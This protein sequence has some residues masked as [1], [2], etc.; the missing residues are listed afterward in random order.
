MDKKEKE[1]QERLARGETAE[2]TPKRRGRKP[3]TAEEKLQSR[4]AKKKSKQQ[5]KRDKREEKKM[6]KQRLK[7]E[8]QRK[9]REREDKKKEKAD[10]RQRPETEEE[11]E[12]K[13]QARKAKYEEFKRAKVEKAEK[14]KQVG[15]TNYDSSVV[16]GISRLLLQKSATSKYVFL[17]FQVLKLNSYYLLTEERRT[18]SLSSKEKRRGKETT[19]SLRETNARIESKFPR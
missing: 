6:E 11:R 1:K 10:K 7:E 15:T 14:R 5:E 19:R 2:P 17:K 9:K 8:K 4:L 3:K 12:A 18:E 13:A 16:I